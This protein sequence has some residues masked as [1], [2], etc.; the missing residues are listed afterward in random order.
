[1]NNSSRDFETM[2]FHGTKY[3]EREMDKVMSNTDLV[4]N[5][6]KFRAMH[7]QM[8]YHLQH[9]TS[10]EV[11]EFAAHMGLEM[12]KEGTDIGVCIPVIVDDRPVHGKLW[13]G[14]TGNAYVVVNLT[15]ARQGPFYEGGSYVLGTPKGFEEAAC[16][17]ARLIEVY[18]NWY[19]ENQTVAA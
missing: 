2:Y 13:I 14:N 7:D 5:V 4:Q 1:M 19:V 12:T 18:Q 11:R 10:K 16:E 3:L 17:I 15:G 6:D 8:R 9:V